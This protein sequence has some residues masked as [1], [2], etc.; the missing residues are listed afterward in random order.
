MS[1][2]SVLLAFLPFYYQNTR[3]TSPEMSAVSPV[4]DTVPTSNHS[5]NGGPFFIVL[6]VIIILT[7]FSYFFG[8]IFIKRQDVAKPC[9]HSLPTEDKHTIILRNEKDGDIEFGCDKRFAASAKVAAIGE[10]ITMLT[11]GRS[12]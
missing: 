12:T 4:S 7:A 10:P 11:M 9:K 1:S 3:K 2:S 6:A 5:S 8:R